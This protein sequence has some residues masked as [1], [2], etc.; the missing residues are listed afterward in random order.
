MKKDDLVFLGHM[1]ELIDKVES[2][3]EGLSRQDFDKDELRQYAIVRAI[4]IIGEAAKN[5]SSSFTSQHSSIPWKDIIGMRDKLIHHYFGVD[6]KAVWDT[7]NNDLPDLKK[8]LLA[9]KK[10]LK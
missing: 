8:K 6:L 5:L 3:S 9:I 1:L 2:F 4:E 10:D 7:M